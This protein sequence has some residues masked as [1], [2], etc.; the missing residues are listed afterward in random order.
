VLLG[1]FGIGCDA[2]LTNQ[3][4]LD[5]VAL[6]AAAGGLAGVR[7]LTEPIAAR[8]EAAMEHVET[9]ASAQAVRA[10]RGVSG[11]VTIRGGEQALE[12]SPA[13]ALTVYLDVGLAYSAAGELARAVADAGSLQ[14]ANAALTALG[15]RTELDLEGD[16]AVPRG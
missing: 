14:E 5:R 16:G 3:E 12:L 13:A 2:E 6:V 9:E 4:V 1:V 11:T 8:L 7:G 10:F 15:V